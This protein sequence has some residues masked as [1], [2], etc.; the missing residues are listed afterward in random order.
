[1]LR[2]I[3]DVTTLDLIYEGFILLF[4]DEMLRKIKGFSFSKIPGSG[5]GLFTKS[6]TRTSNEKNK[7]RVDQNDWAKTDYK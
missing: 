7:N 2:N 6:G 1:M 4:W 3:R 5:P